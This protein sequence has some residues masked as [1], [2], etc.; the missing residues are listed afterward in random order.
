M[1]IDLKPN[2]KHILIS[3][4]L[5]LLEADNN[6]RDSFRRKIDSLNEEKQTFEL[7]INEL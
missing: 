6:I 5:A 3:R 2:E 1:S 7:I 4:Y